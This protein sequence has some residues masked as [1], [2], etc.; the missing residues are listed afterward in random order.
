MDN[1]VSTLKTRQT[2]AR[3]GDQEHFLHK[4]NQGAIESI[5]RELNRPFAEIAALY[6]DIFTH[7][8]ARAEVTDYLPIFVARTVRLHYQNSSSH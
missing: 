8:K 6:A 2:K 7:L 4:Q 1:A 5:A 3:H